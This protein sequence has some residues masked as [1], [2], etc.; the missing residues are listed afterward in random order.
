MESNYK[1]SS[2]II[3]FKSL[4]SRQAITTTTLSNKTV[5]ANVEFRENSHYTKEGDF[6]IDIAIY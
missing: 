2:L 3:I 6:T 1:S 4:I 5:S